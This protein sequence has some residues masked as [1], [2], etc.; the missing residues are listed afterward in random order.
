MKAERFERPP[1]RNPHP[2]DVIKHLKRRDA[3][4]P[5]WIFDKAVAIG[6]ETRKLELESRQKVHWNTVLDD[7]CE[8]FSLGFYK[9][10]RPAA[11]DSPEAPIKKMFRVN[12]RNLWRAIYAYCQEH[13]HLDRRGSASMGLAAEVVERINGIERAEQKRLADL[14]PTMLDR[15]VRKMFPVSGGAM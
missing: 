1:H 5:D 11:P 7:I 9:A 13:K 15:T 3:A 8:G 10:A 2:S 14:R 6:A 4:A 12:N